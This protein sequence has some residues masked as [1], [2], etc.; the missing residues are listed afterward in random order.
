MGWSIKAGFSLLL[1]L[2]VL[3]GYGQEEESQ[4]FKTIFGSDFESGG[5]GAPELKLGPVNGVSSLFVGGRGGW[6]IGHRLVIGGGG[7]G[8][9]TNNTFMEDPADRPSN[10][11]VDSTRN[12]KLDMGYG[13]LLLEFIAMPK[14]AVHLSF[15]VLIGGGGSNLGAQTFVGQSNYYPEGWATYD[16]IENSGFF[17]VEPGVFI[18]L[19]MTKFFRLSAGGSYRFISGV[20]MQRLNSND[21]SGATFSL[22]LK[23]GGF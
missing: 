12:I 23:F 11:P 16:F 10:L 7:Y 8:M 4:E 6:I 1:L 3:F 20:N 14:S 13:G 22:A 17:V 2:F 19:N 18:E 15:P 9:T 21:L 5:Y